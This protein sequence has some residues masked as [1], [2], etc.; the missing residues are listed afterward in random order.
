MNRRKILKA[1]IATAGVA[2]SSIFTK[3]IKAL[4]LIKR[5]HGPSLS[6]IHLPGGPGHENV[7][8]STE[9]K[10]FVAMRPC[11]IIVQHGLALAHSDFVIEYMT[12]ENVP[13]FLSKS[14]G[15]SNLKMRSILSILAGD[16]RNWKE[17]G[18]VD[19]EIELYYNNLKVRNYGF[20]QLLKLNGVYESF[21]RE[22][23]KNRFIGARGYRD[24]ADQASSSE[25]AIVFGLRTHYPD[26]LRLATV[27]NKY[28][29]TESSMHEYPL[30][31]D[32]VVSVRKQGYDS[33]AHRLQGYLSTVHREYDTEAELL[34]M[35]GT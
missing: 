18:G 16:I 21:H 13:I 6:P 12:T 34:K 4:P 26:S 24:L 7:I 9:F 35:F 3:K 30:T 10:L 32:A 27:E 5:R 23:N 22:S 31:V 1:T 28:P 20:I 11:K 8:G 15:L 25:S 14:I 17:L 33:N 19:S 29:H 2:S